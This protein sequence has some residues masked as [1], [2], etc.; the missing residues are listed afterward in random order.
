MKNK[1]MLLTVG[2]L[3]AWAGPTMAADEEE[4]SLMVSPVETWTC[5]YHDGKGAADLQKA[6]DVWNAWMD[7]E[8][9]TNY[10]AITVTPWY[11]GEDTFDIGW[12]GFW[13]DGAAMGAG[14]DSYLTTGGDAAAGF[15]EAIGCES[16]SGF[17]STMIKSPG[18]GPPPDKLVLYFSDCNIKD[19]AEFGA[20]MDGLR[21]WSDYL[22]EQEYNNGLWI[23]F[24]AFGSGDMDFDFKQVTSY[25][26]HTA[27]G[28]GW[29]KYGN[30]GGW[31][32]RN[33]LLGDK[34]DCDTT[35]V[36]NGTFRRKLPP[37]EE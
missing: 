28:A 13:T 15:A 14:T 4:D 26:S 5:N 35:R 7:K 11:Y 24:P 27:A 30:G 6:I 32:K 3:L 20:V 2:T 18:E 8:G 22:T 9:N 17:A 33:E 36:Y 16:H 12:I 31:Q 23:M 1:M 25:D 19:G 10:G 29:D 21:A 34:L 37:P